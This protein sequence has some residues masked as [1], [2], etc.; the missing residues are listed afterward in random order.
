MYQTLEISFP[1]DHVRLIRL[2]RPESMNALNTRMGEELRTVFRE[3]VV[4]AHPEIRV[5]I[6]T[7]SGNRAFCAGADLKE[8]K[9]MSD[10]AW[11]QQHVIFEEASEALWRCPIPVLAAVNGVALGGGLE[12]ALACDLII[13]ARSARFGQPEVSRGII[14]GAGGT[15]RLPRRIGIARAKEMLYSGQPIDSSQA[16][17]WGLVNRVVDDEALLEEALGLAQTIAANGPISLRQIKKA[18]DRGLEMSLADG[19]VLELEAYNITVP[20]DDRHEGVN[21]FNEKRAPVFQNR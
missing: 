16:L 9:G 13:A 15:Q 7:G 4:S 1:R 6:L 11:R 10:G 21:A 8:R 17:D 18:V 2:I 14:P 3:N 20:T 19:L 12:L 5:S